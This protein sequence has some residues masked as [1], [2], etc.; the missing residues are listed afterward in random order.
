MCPE[1]GKLLSVELILESIIVFI[2]GIAFGSF[3]CVCVDRLPKGLSVVKGHSMCDHCGKTLGPRELIPI[4]S[5]LALSGRC[6]FC[7]AKIPTH[8]FLT[9]AFGGVLLLVLFL[10]TLHLGL[11][12]PI[13]I[14]LAFIMFSLLGIFLTDV[15]SGIIPD[16]F[17][18]IMGMAS[19]IL[20][21]FFNQGSLFANFGAGIVSFMLFFALFAITRGRGMGFGDVKFAG[22]IGLFLGFPGTIIGLYVA[23]LTGAVISLILVLTGRKKLRGDT[24]PFGPFLVIGTVFAYFFGNIIWQYFI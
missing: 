8:V 24:I 3:I 2:F 7:K 18:V 1:R 17:L 16:E 10:Y 20:V 9:E 19:V 11:S 13:F 4:V 5:Y 6:S 14:F 23:F 22:V 21:V 12:L 15:Y